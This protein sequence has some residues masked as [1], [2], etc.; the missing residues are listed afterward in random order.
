MEKRKSE[1]EGV[2]EGRVRGKGG[3]GKKDHRAGR[4]EREQR[5]KEG[6]RALEAEREEGRGRTGKG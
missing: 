5:T 6:K 2:D 4:C 3:E 1:R